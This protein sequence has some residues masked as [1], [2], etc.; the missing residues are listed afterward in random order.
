MRPKGDAEKYGLR[1]TN[2]KAVTAAPD[3]VAKVPDYSLGAAHEWVGEYFF[4]IE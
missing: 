4:M 2:K 3:L 1:E